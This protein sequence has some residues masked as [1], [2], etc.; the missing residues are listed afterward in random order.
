MRISRRDFLKT[1]SVLAVASV[2]LSRLETA[3]AGPGSP[4]VIWLQGQ[5]CTGCSVSFLNSIY[6]ATV[7]SLLLNTINLEYHPNVMASAGTLAFNNAQEQKPSAGEM[8]LFADQWLTSGDN[9]AF[10]LNKNKKVDL[11]DFALL[12]KKGYILIVEGAIPTG[13]AGLFCTVG[14]IPL[15]QAL[16]SFVNNAATVIALG[17][18]ASF[19]GLAAG[20]PNPTSAK[21]LTAAL[22][23]L[24]I[25][26]SVINIPGCPVHPDWLVGTLSYILVNG[27]A[28][29]LDSNKRPID[30]FGSTV[31]SKCPNLSSYSSF[32]SR[33]HDG[34]ISE[35]R[36]CLRSG[37]HSNSDSNIPNPRL[38]GGTGC[39]FGLN[40]KGRITY[41][42]CPTRKWNSPAASQAGVN[43]CIGSKVPCH[44]CTEPTFPDG[45]SPFF[46]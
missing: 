28:P 46:L 2:E 13:D 21:S 4:S 12:A 34:H 45:V 19:G 15:I 35:N 33:D 41:S 6:Y 27:T 23:Y 20:A 32:T 29:S 5:G 37:C 31:H 30:Y 44:G 8:A 17:T 11:L 1:A 10:D 18:C 3:L 16:P 40:C 25:S 22:S 24:G 9:I 43:W 42:D 14:E 7:D 36:G 26:K 39:L 38:L